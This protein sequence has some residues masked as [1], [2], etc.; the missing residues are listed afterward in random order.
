M[1]CRGGSLVS[2]PFNLPFVL[3]NYCPAHSLATP[4]ALASHA[5]SQ[6]SEAQALAGY[7]AG[8]MADLVQQLAEARAERGE[9]AAKLAEAREEV[10]HLRSGEG[11]RG[12][13]WCGGWGR[14]PAPR[15]A[16]MLSRAGVEKSAVARTAG[17]CLAACRRR[18]I[19]RLLSPALLPPGPDGELRARIERLEKDV[20]IQ[21]NRADV[22]SL[23]K[24][25]HDR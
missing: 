20:V 21:R 22:N 16:G 7:S 14:S 17:C 2:K 12:W 18:Q 6:L 11:W 10:S 9:A 13:M 19:A 3:P 23:F 25:E 15:A 8:E 24:E 4:S 1:C 5:H